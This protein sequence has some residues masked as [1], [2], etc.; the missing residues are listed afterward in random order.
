MLLKANVNA[1]YVGIQQRGL[2]PPSQL[3]PPSAHLRTKCF[4]DCSLL[5]H[6][7]CDKLLG[8]TICGDFFFCVLTMCLSIGVEEGSHEGFPNDDT[9]IHGRTRTART[10]DP[11]RDLS[12]FHARARTT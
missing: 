3:P 2:T 6:L 5:M 7:L 4:C 1:V 10:E 11:G 12:V 9:R 8:A